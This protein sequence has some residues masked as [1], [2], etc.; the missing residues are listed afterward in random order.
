M[1]DFRQRALTIL[2][3]DRIW[4]AYAIADLQPAF[5]PDCVWSLRD[6]AEGAS[7]ALLYYGLTTPV[8]FTFGAPA[9][10]ATSLDE[11][12]AAGQLPPNVDLAAREEHETVVGRW[13]DST[14]DRKPMLRLHLADAGR[15]PAPAAELVRLSGSDA[16][17]LQA[18]YAHGGPF[19]PDAFMPAQVAQGVFF[20]V[21]GVDGALIAAGG[22][23][24]WDPDA[25]IAAIGNMYTHPEHRGRGLAAQVLAAIVQTLL[26]A[27][28]TTIVLNVNAHNH[29]ARRLYERFGFELHC[30]FIEGVA[31]KKGGGNGA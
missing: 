24:L 17:R 12:A 23:H 26:A 18:L 3:Q 14:G 31:V 25:G 29:G 27:G 30:P 11:W 28:V 1:P 20:G 15:V 22:T 10:L 2:Q 7:A 9:A 5:A 16:P 21:T 8:L 13:F 6:G 4:A 19:T